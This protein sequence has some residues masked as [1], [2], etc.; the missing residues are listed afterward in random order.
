[1]PLEAIKRLTLSDKDKKSKIGKKDPLR[2][3]GSR[4]SK[5]S[6]KGWL[7]LRGLIAFGVVC[8]FIAIIWLVFVDLAV[9][10]AIETVGTRMVGARV[11]LASV[12][13]TLSP[14]GIT[15]N[16]LQ[17]TDPEN[18]MTNAFEVSVIKA[19]LE[20]GPLYMRKIIIDEL[21]VEGLRFASNRKKSGAIKGTAVK[22]VAAREKTATSQFKMPSFE[23]LDV[24]TILASENFETR[25]II[26]SLRSDIEKAK[27]D[28][29]GQIKG[30]PGKEQIEEY[31]RRFKALEKSAKGG[32]L[33]GILAGGAEFASLQKD[34]KKD[35]KVIKKANKGL[36]R[37]IK[38][39]ESRINRLSKAVDNDVRRI[40]N[41]YLM[42]TEMIKN[43]TLM[44]FGERVA[45]VAEKG[46]YWYKRLE[47]FIE[48]S[49]A[50]KG[51][52]EV[53]ENKR[54][55][56]AWIRFKEKESLP[57]FLIRKALVSMITERGTIGGVITDVTPDQKML[58][59]PTV[60]NFST[61]TLKGVKAL[62]LKG[63]LNHINATKA[64]DN[65]T[66]KVVGFNIKD[67][68]ASVLPITVKSGLIDLDLLVGL[69]AEPHGQRLGSK[70]NMAFSRL[71]F[72]KE[73]STGNQ[74]QDVMIDAIS[75]IDKFKLRGS[76]TGKIQD[77]ALTG[78]K[79]TISGGLDKIMEKAVASVITK[80]ALG[81]KRELRSGIMKELGGDI[82]G[83]DGELGG[84]QGLSKELTGRLDLGKIDGGNGGS[85][86]P[87]IKF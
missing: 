41:K 71:R 8:V 6:Q 31:K 33:L 86:F 64:V 15:L 62:T 11:E 36:E 68:N 9:K 25:N 34:L 60:F 79:L 46:T 83:L 39:Y 78:E 56:G 52:V 20:S 40:T 43:M 61:D 26:E 14:L 82:N 24:Q 49:S 21:K 22:K 84:L 38:S 55:N 17:V 80:Q 87:N 54:G 12:D 77:G 29:S 72:V 44:L 28:W 76:L 58:G 69:R 67:I 53:V 18:P 65:L 66:L 2:F 74:M 63:T 23:K 35:L 5:E 59:R 19:S 57:D 42:P 30:L 85:S 70:S 47:P 48:R 75:G 32:G 7:R 51:K 13:L 73:K 10:K 3:E 1:V 16:G 50:P 45:M 37:T 27:G 81:F 4:P